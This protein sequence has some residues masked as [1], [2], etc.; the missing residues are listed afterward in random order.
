M[1]NKKGVSP[2]IATVL[3]I[4]MVLVLALIIF[5]WFRGFTGEKCEKFDQACELTCDDVKFDVSYVNGVFFIKNE[6]NIPIYNLQVELK[7]DGYSET[8]SIKDFFDEGFSSTVLSVGGVV[9]GTP[10]E[11][12]L[13]SI[14][15]IPVI[16]GTGDDGKKPFVCDDRYG[17]TYK[18]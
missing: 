6:G 10:T 3:L 13:N 12:D 16:L 15:F 8:L 17:E 14:K 7:G 18:F 2:V 4:A 1:L 5:L 11:T 9:Q